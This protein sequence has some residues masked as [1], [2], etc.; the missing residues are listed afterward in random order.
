MADRTLGRYEKG[1]DS[2]RS[3]LTI[4]WGC[5]II[6]SRQLAQALLA[7]HA[8]HPYTLHTVVSSLCALLT[9]ARVSSGRQLKSSTESQSKSV[10]QGE[11]RN[12]NFSSIL[13]KAKGKLSAS[14]MLHCKIRRHT[15]PRILSQERTRSVVQAY[16]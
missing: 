3:L 5:L 7:V 6:G 15:S 4:H 10:G 13:G 12:L 11:N 16:P 1:T 9:A 8:P 2:S 14:S